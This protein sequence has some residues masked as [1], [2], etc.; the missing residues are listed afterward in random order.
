MTDVFISHANVNLALAE[1]IKF[2][3]QKGLEIL[4]LM[5]AGLMLFGK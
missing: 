1:A 3:K 5:V 4:G 2:E